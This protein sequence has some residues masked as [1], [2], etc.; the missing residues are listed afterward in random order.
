MNRQ[1]LTVIKY[2]YVTQY[3]DFVRWC[4]EALILQVGSLLRVTC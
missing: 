3:Y 1:G 2:Y 4:Y